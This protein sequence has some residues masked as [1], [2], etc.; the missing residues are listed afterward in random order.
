VL[1]TA[2]AIASFLS[3][4]IAAHL[5][6]LLTATGLSARDAVL[7]GSLIGPMQV[8]GRIMEFAFA[9]RPGACG[10]HAGIRADGRVARRAHAGARRGS[11]RS[12]SRFPTAGATVMTI[13]RGTVP[14]ELFGTRGYGALLG[15]LALPQFI[16]KA[17]A[18]LAVSLLFVVDPARTLTPWTLLLLAL[19][20]LVAYR[21]AVRAAVTR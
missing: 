14:A 20:A 5:I 16:L 21:A 13:A 18:P 3:S 12:R 17:V 8:A 15:R 2:L 10:R 6:G 19:L 1:A 11:S 4:A 9:R 7:I